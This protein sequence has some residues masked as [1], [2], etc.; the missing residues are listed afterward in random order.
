MIEK[1]KEINPSIPGM[2]V[3]QSVYLII[4]EAL[5]LLI[6]DTPM[7]LAIGFAAGVFYAAFA[8]FHMSFRIR[9]VVYGGANTSATFVL[10]YVIRLAVMLVLF[11]VLYFLDIGDLLGAI[12]GI[13][14]MK[15]AAYLQ[16]FTDKLITKIQKGR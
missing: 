2:L 14:S 7:N 4:G 1:I 8:T 6:A 15:V 10:G 3:V 12:L 9:K 13:F 5:I 16:P 11:S